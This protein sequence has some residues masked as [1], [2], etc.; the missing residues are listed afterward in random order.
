MAYAS[1]AVR[2]LRKNELNYSTTERECL[3]IKFA[4]EKFRPYIEDDTFTVITDHRAL[5]CLYKRKDPVGRLGRWAQEL[6]SYD[7]KIVHRKDDESVLI[8]AIEIKEITSDKWNKKRLYQ[9]SKH[10]R[11]YRDWNVVN[12]NIYR[13]KPSKDIE[14]IM[15]DLDAWK[16]VTPKDK[17]DKILEEM[18]SEPS[19]GHSGVD[20]TYNRLVHFYYCPGA[21]KDTARFVKNCKICQ[22]LKTEQRAQV[23]LM[24]TR[25]VDRPWKIIAA[26]LM[27]EFPR[28]KASKTPAFLIFVHELHPPKLWRREVKAQIE[29]DPEKSSSANRN[30]NESID[31]ADINDSASSQSDGSVRKYNTWDRKKKKLEKLEKKRK[32]EKEN[33]ISETHKANDIKENENYILNNNSLKDKV[34]D[35]TERMQKLVHVH[36]NTLVQ[37]DKEKR[38]DVY[39]LQ[40]INGKNLSSSCHAKALKEFTGEEKPEKSGNA[41]PPEKPKRKP[42]RPPKQRAKTKKQQSAHLPPPLSTQQ[43]HPPIAQTTIVANSSSSESSSDSEI[44]PRVLKKLLKY[45]KLLSK[46]K[47]EKKSRKVRA[48]SERVNSITSAHT[49]N[50]PTDKESVK[51]AA[52]TSFGARTPK[53]QQSSHRDKIFRELRENQQ[54]YLA[55]QER[56]RNLETS[57]RMSEQERQR[58]EDVYTLQDINGKNLSSSCHAKALKEF[59]GEEKPEKSGNAAPPEKPKRKPGRPP[60]QRAK[61]KKQ[62]SAHLPPPLSTQQQ[63]VPAPT[64][65]H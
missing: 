8:N 21:Y 34:N 19:A 29:T 10:P 50:S 12:G 53:H 40:D 52:E 65:H 33:N 30:A 46:E 26:D 59:T 15:T 51:D 28:S 13:Y 63:H 43:Q 4:I 6:I 56:R 41:A 57:S 42:G 64:Q 62:Q 60:K 16:L 58:R 37:V 3:A 11:R 54:Q 31:K 24:G 25:D 9:I 45:Q 61:T 55:E 7:F 27:E 18:H 20:K 48:K 47:S 38:E 44:D 1:R 36:D 2:A 35:W 17:L 32:A 39:T 23:G 14:D 22:Q 49:G 5:Q